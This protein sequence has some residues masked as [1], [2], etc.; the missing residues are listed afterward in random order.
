MLQLQIVA[1]GPSQ[2]RDELL[3]APRV[4]LFLQ[5]PLPTAA[6]LLLLE[7]QLRRQIPQMFASVIQVND[8]DGTW[9]VLLRKIPDPGRAVAEDDFAARPAPS[10]S[11]GFVEQARA[12]SGGVLNRAAIRGRVLVSNRAASRVAARLREHAAQLD[13]AGAGR[14][15]VLAFASGR[16]S[17]RNRHARAVHLDVENRN[18]RSAYRREFQLHS[19]LDLGLFARRKAAAAVATVIIRSFDNNRAQH[20]DELL[21][22]LAGVARLSAPGAVLLRFVRRVVVQ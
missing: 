9:K 6:T 4:E 13:L 22:A 11:P 10:P 3:D 15:T 5:P 19:A 21:R 14:A 2:R 1:C 7:K 18:F 20:G 12:E 17:G 8:L 16:F